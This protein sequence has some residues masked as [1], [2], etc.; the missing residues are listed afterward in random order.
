MVEDIFGNPI[1]ETDITLSE[2]YPKLNPGQQEAVAR[3]RDFLS[4]PSKLVWKDK[5]YDQLEAAGLISSHTGDEAFQICKEYV[6]QNSFLFTGGPGY[7]KTYASEV[8][9]EVFELD[10]C[11]PTYQACAVLSENLSGSIVSTLASL[12]G[13]AKLDRVT[14][15]QGSDDFYLRSIDSIAS[16]YSATGML[17]GIFT[18][19]CF[20]IDEA[21]MVGGNNKKPR[22]ISIRENGVQR[23]VTLSNDTFVAIVCRLQDRVMHHG[24]FNC[25]PLP[26]K[27]LFL[28]D[29]DQ[30]PP[31]GTDHDD[32]ALLL[33]RLLSH[34]NDHHELTE[35]MRT[36]KPDIKY[37]IEA[38]KE[39]LRRLRKLRKEQ[40]ILSTDSRANANTMIIPVPLRESSENVRYF[41]DAGK[42]VDQFLELYKNR[43]EQ[44]KYNP[45]YV[46]IVN[47]NR[48]A[49]V[50]TVQFVD[51]IRTRMFGDPKVKY[52]KGETL[53]S[54]SNFTASTS[55]LKAVTVD[56]D[57]RVF[58]V[59]VEQ[60][61]LSRILPSRLKISINLP[62]L[63][64][65]YGEDRIQV[66]AAS[67]E[68][69]D[70]INHIAND[71]RYSNKAMHLKKAEQ[72]FFGLTSNIL[73]Y[74][75]WL[76]LASCA[77]D[78]GYAYVVNNFKIQG[79]SL[80]YSMVDEGN[81]LSAPVSPKKR[82]QYVYTG[83]SRAREKVFI[84]NPVNLYD[85][86][87]I[88]ANETT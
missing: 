73:H 76:Q 45:N 39:E 63:T 83:L 48:E 80:R 46:S 58:V 14:N 3:I 72:E 52:Y 6:L 62:R 27:F 16:T 18:G 1:K 65:Q 5:E 10:F 82:L 35:L 2:K 75:Q 23:S 55:A 32:D 86:E 88:C 69:I 84:L 33:E 70:T 40:G 85:A 50:R 8:I 38:Y 4:S 24:Q 9:T 44:Y 36:D 74:S 15:D 47:Y 7:G 41:K 64:L 59:S 87:Q 13:T 79:S 77:P 49:H 11:A 42:F 21:S 43:P 19:D 34:Q 56:K 28:G 29:I 68:F 37:L 30:T 54:R 81:I 78:F 25:S 57:S 31:V 66:Y 12:L 51:R 26:S 61:R 53:L 67:K 20:M 71:N 17:P 60:G 22:T